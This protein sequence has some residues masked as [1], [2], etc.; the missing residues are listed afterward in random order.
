MLFDAKL[1]AQMK[2]TAVYVN[3]GRGKT[4]NEA[5]L[6]GALESNT[7]KGAILDVYYEEPLPQESSLWS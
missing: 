6:I 2:P 4:N 5:D 3:I 7:I 1:F